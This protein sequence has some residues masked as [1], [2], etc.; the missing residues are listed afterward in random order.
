M[1]TAFV[2]LGCIALVIDLTTIVRYEVS[3]Y[4]RKSQ[5]REP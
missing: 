5:R 3:E 2:V 4:R 1:N